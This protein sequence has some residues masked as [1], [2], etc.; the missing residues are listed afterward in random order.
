MFS[1]NQ[2]NLPNRQNVFARPTQIL[3]SQFAVVIHKNADGEPVFLTRLR[4]PDRRGAYFGLFGES[5][6]TC[7]NWG[8][9]VKF[10]DDAVP[11]LMNVHFYDFCSKCLNTVAHLLMMIPDFID[12]V[13]VD[14]PLRIGAWSSESKCTLQPGDW[15]FSVNRDCE[16][17]GLWTKDCMPFVSRSSKSCFLVG[18]SE[19]NLRADVDSILCRRAQSK[20][21]LATVT[22]T[23]F[24]SIASITPVLSLQNIVLVDLQVSL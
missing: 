1:E 21:R 14:L 3:K 7:N 10:P 20:F 23:K 15:Q 6:A 9:F 13:T 19:C 16:W 8:N 18:H 22:S 2:P 12:C 24:S 17:D 4:N 5:T 11:M